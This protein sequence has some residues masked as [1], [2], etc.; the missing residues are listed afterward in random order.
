MIKKIHEKKR[1]NTESSVKHLH[2]RRFRGVQNSEVSEDSDVEWSFSEGEYV[3]PLLKQLYPTAETSLRDRADF[4]FITIGRLDHFCYRHL[5]LSTITEIRKFQR[6]CQIELCMHREHLYEYFRFIRHNSN[7]LNNVK[8]AAD[9][10]KNENELTKQT[11]LIKKLI[12]TRKET[13]FVNLGYEP[14]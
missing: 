2:K 3:P 10:L 11:N 7:L 4:D 6:K 8:K 9:D 5:N 1:R 14:I 12:D 13:N